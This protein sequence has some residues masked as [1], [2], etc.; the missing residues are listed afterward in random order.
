MQQ[1]GNLFQYLFSLSSSSPILAKCNEKSN[2]N[3]C[4][5][6]N[7]SNKGSFTCSAFYGN[8]TISWQFITAI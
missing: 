6:D 8:A 2:Q 5:L 4:T 1:V 3:N 7:N